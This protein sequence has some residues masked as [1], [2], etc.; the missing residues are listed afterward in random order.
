[1]PQSPKQFWTPH[2]LVKS[3]TNTQ[4]TRRR[5]WL[6]NVI[7]TDYR[8]KKKCEHWSPTQ[9]QST[10]ARGAKLEILV[11][12]LSVRLVGT[13]WQFLQDPRVVC[14]LHDAQTM[15]LDHFSTLVRTRG[16]PG[17]QSQACTKGTN[18]N[19]RQGPISAHHLP[20][21]VIDASFDPL[22]RA[23]VR[24]MKL[25]FHRA[26]CDSFFWSW[27]FQQCLWR[28]CQRNIDACGW[29]QN[30]LSSKSTN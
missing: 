29:F 5:D 18:D 28:V 15:V 9:V 24:A 26:K 12:A 13:L 27:P 7:L 22:W 14:Q 20:S 16:I 23:P 8:I 10:V 25:I 2:I 17:V 21:M 30:A 11:D 3:F 1:M 4:A 6:V 19:C